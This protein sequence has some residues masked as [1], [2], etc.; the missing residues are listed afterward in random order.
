MGR[1]RK[2]PNRRRAAALAAVPVVSTLPMLAGMGPASASESN[3]WDALAKCESTNNWDI[4]TGNG[5]YGGLQFSKGTWLAFG[6]G[7][8]ASRADL[9]TKTEQITIAK[10]VQKA[11]GWNAWPGCNSKLGLA[12]LAASGSSTP[13]RDS[14]PSRASRSTHRAAVK[15]STTAKAKTSTTRTK[16]TASKATTHRSA[17]KTVKV[18]KARTG[19][20]STHLVHAG[21]TLTGIAHMHRITGGWRTL[22]KLNQDVVKDANLI[23]PGQLVKLAADRR[24]A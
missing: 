17:K 23:Y 2:T 24:F 12:H 22:A 15:S 14:T 19:L 5:Y 16:T 1:H 13:S 11:Q 10:K 4:N 8:Y 7:K 21:D 20:R 3:V 18:T 6:G 9:A